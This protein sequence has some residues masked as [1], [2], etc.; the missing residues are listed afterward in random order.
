MVQTMT[1]ARILYRAKPVKRSEPVRLFATVLI[2]ITLCFCVELT[3]AADLDQ[4]AD[5]DSK[6]ANEAEGASAS[7]WETSVMLMP[8]NL[9]LNMN[10]KYVGQVDAKVDPRSSEGMVKKDR[11][12][13]MLK[14]LIGRSLL[15]DLTKHLANTPEYVSFDATQS[16]GVAIEFDSLSLSL[17]VTTDAGDLMTQS[18]ALKSRRNEPNPDLYIEPSNFTVGVNIAATQVFV[19]QGG[20]VLA[21]DPQV[22]LNGLLNFGGFGGVTVEGGARYSGNQED[23]WERTTVLASKDFFSSA[24]RLSAGE[25]TPR[26]R[27]FQGSQRMLGVGLHRSYSS[28]RPFEIVRPTGRSKFNLEEESKIDVYV[29]EILVDTIDLP[30]G[31]YSLTDFPIT[32][33][34]NDVRL[35]IVGRSGRAQTLTFDVYG[36]SELLAPGISDFG[37]FLGNRQGQ[38]E[39][40]YSAGFGATAYYR[41][42]FTGSLSAGATLQASETAQQLGLLFTYGGDYGLF[43]FEAAAS[44][45]SEDQELGNAFRLSYRHSLSLLSDNDLRISANGE[46]RTERFQGAFEDL[47]LAPQI[48]SS[49]VQ[50]S[51]IGPRGWSANIGVSAAESRGLNSGRLSNFNGTVSRRVGNFQIGASFGLSE[52]VSGEKTERF[53]ITLGYR[54]SGAYSSTAQYN[55]VDQQMQ[56]ALNRRSLDRVGGLNLGAQIQDSHRGKRYRLNGSY[57]H[58]RFES[59]VQHSYSAAGADNEESLSRTQV[60][61]GSF[62]GYSGGAFGVGRPVQSG[63]VLAKKHRS[64]RNSKVEFRN[65]SQFV[66]RTGLLGTAVIPLSRPYAVTKFNVHVDPLPVGYD[67]GEG[68]ITVFPGHGSS[69]ATPIGSDASRTA[70][71]FLMKDGEPWPLASGMVSP[72]GNAR[73]KE[74]YQ[75]PLFTNRGGRFVADR[76]RAGDYE[77][78]VDD[79]V[80]AKFKIAKKQEGL[81]NLGKVGDAE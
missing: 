29:N 45:H 58:N 76:L 56:L 19:K 25:V 5:A 55:S 42:G 40:D 17:N 4:T 16:V 61:L 64:L 65:G 13:V 34:S 78:I 2:A 41:R 3:S 57:N 30:K 70:M 62:F 68:D 71:G 14:P 66:A 38:R 72:T 47:E 24:L 49:A 46:Y 23:P 77:I 8:L 22:A 12:I 6:Q 27:A 18:Y 79:Q 36:G 37:V 81:V 44:Y 28:I 54:P 59:A 7:K 39:F 67:I 63:F 11:L 52:S 20:E 32:S 73:D 21:Q 26:T 15:N 75:R 35:E 51:W 53:G 10:G 74:K 9:G 31:A 33:K 69:Y 80:V 43:D 48:W 60:R 50:A 1:Q